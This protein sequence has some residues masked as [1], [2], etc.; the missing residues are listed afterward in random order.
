VRFLGGGATV[1]SLCLAVRELGASR[2][3]VWVRDPSK[4]SAD[5][6]LDVRRL[7]DPMDEPADLLISTIPSDAVPPG[8]AE[9][10]GAVFDVIYNPWPTPLMRAAEAAGR[11]VISG[12][13]LLAHQAAL[14]VDLMTGASVDPATLR[15]AALSALVD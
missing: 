12:L 3:E 8:V 10:A 4:M 15:E 11:P 5:A 13:D 9:S 1:D 6:G 2:V 7:G 14:Q